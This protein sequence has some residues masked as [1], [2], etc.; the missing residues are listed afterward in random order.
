MNIEHTPVKKRRIGF[1]TQLTRDLSFLERVVSFCTQ[2]FGTTGFL[3]GNVIAFA[4]WIL[5]NTGMIPGLS[6]FDPYPFGFLTMVVSL[7]AIV[8]SIAV[9]ITQNKESEIADLREETDFEIN[10]RAENEITTILNM[11]DEIHDHLGLPKNEDDELRSMKER[12]N[13]EE[14]EEQILRERR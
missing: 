3:V 13:I 2:W 6:P 12:T 7:E 4:L 5:W 8:L 9:L 14:I 1:R 10:V 11:L